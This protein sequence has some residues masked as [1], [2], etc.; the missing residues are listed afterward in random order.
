MQP[1]SVRAEFWFEPFW[2]AEGCFN[3]QEVAI[4]IPHTSRCVAV[5]QAP[6]DA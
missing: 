3:E 5:L 1:H 6:E 4:V 2:K